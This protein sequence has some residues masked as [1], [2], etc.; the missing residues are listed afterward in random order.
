[1]VNDKEDIVETFSFRNSSGLETGYYYPLKNYTFELHTNQPGK[2]KLKSAFK[3]SGGEWVTVNSSPGSIDFIVLD[4]T[5]PVSGVSL[6]K[7]SSTI[8]ADS[9]E[10]LTATIAPET[11]ANKKVTW[12]S[13]NTDVATVSSNGLVTGVSEGTSTIT[14]ITENGARNATCLITV[15]VVSKKAL[16]VLESQEEPLN[17]YPNPA[18]DQITVSGL[19]ESGILTLFDVAGRQ[20]IKHQIVSPQET[21][22]VSHLPQGYHVIMV[23]QGKN[24]ITAKILVE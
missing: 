1:L 21:I 6:N 14:V 3:P 4:T 19:Q 16:D 15:V 12:S 17:V 22:S 20:L 23:V 9:T 13:S 2:Y 5:V 7:T 18:H 24:I 10:L 8:P 11:V